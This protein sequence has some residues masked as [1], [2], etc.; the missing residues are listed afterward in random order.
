MPVRSSVCTYSP[1]SVSNNSKY[2]LPSSLSIGHYRPL[3]SS[4][5]NVGSSASA[6]PAYRSPSS[7]VGEKKSYSGGRYGSV[8]SPHSATLNNGGG[9]YSSLSST[10]SSLASSY[11]PLSSTHSSFVGSTRY[12]NNLSTPTTGYSTGHSRYSSTGSTGSA[13]SLSSASSSLLDRAAASTP[14]DAY[15]PSSQ[16]YN[17]PSINRRLSY[18]TTR[19]RLGADDSTSCDLPSGV[20]RGLVNLGN[21]CYMNAGLQS[22][23]SIDAFRTFIL[24]RCS[25]SYDKPLASELSNLFKNMKSSTSAPISP[26]SFKCA[27][28]RH[29]SKFSGLGQQDAQEFLRYLINGVHEELNQAAKRPRRSTTPRPPHTADEAWSQYRDIVDDSPL[30]DLVVG[31]MCSTIICS[32]C[33]NKSHCWDP[34]WDLSLPLTRGRHSCKLSE[35]VQDFIAKETLDSDERPICSQC[36]KATKSTKQ[37]D[38]CRLPQLMILHLKKFT[39]DGYKMSSPEVR[40]DDKLTF[41][42]ITY[43]LT[44]CISHHGHSSSSGHYTSHSKYSSRWFHFNDDR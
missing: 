37:M 8:Y 21:T 39:N 27:F 10:T 7:I 2:S 16:H 29:Q 41:N 26:A 3:S 43:N 9:S 17:Y 32:I 13:S 28:S 40:V 35:I 24:T 6:S 4:S 20:P 44:A 30:V 12:S 42:N 38:L 25:S 31:Q 36:K 15:Y 18:T 1:S 34:F 22:L 33:Q 23:Y 19:A 11:R 5:L 14:T